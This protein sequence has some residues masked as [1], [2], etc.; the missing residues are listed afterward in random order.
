M[1]W[2]AKAFIVCFCESK[3]GSLNTVFVTPEILLQG[4]STLFVFLSP[5]KLGLFWREILDC[6]FSSVPFLSVA[7]WLAGYLTL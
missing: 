3:R 1:F 7:I 4:V 6:V 2:L 5:F